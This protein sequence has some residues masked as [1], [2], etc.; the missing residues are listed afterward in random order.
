LKQDFQMKMRA[1]KNKQ[2]LLRYAGAPRMSRG[3]R[4]DGMRT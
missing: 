4:Q 1:F 2:S 3:K